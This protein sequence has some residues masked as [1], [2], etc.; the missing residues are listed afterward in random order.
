MHAVGGRGLGLREAPGHALVGEEH[1]LLYEPGRPGSTAHHDARGAARLVKP[2]LG[3]NGLKVDGP[4][5]VAHVLPQGAIL[6]KDVEEVG[7]PGRLLGR[8]G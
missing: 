4:A 1:G 5:L 7:H 2:H 6:V 8:T 3:L